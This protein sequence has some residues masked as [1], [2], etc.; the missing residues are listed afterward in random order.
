MSWV[1]QAGMVLAAWAILLAVEHVGVGIGYRSLF[2]AAWE[3]ALAR[4]HLAPVALAAL[5][6]MAVLT[7]ALARLLSRAEKDVHARRAVGVLAA[8]AAGLTAVGVSSGRRMAP[9][10]VRLPFVTLIAM[11]A[12]ALS[13]MLVP[14]LVRLS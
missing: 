8:T 1:S 14:R 9:L 2:V 13:L 5:L 7:V 12:M 11:V 10:L 4:T 6:P 3:M